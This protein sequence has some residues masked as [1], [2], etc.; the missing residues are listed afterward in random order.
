MWA[1]LESPCCMLV[2]SKKLSTEWWGPHYVGHVTRN[3]TLGGK[4]SVCVMMII[5]PFINLTLVT[6][7]KLTLI[8]H[9]RPTLI[10]LHNGDYRLLHVLRLSTLRESH[11]CYHVL[12]KPGQ[13]VGVAREK[14]KFTSLSKNRWPI[15]VFN[16][17]C[18]VLNELNNCWCNACL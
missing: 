1:F 6:R 15:I 10:G 14:K 5:I 18:P 9:L 17:A 8:Y 12:Q 7:L 2:A 16:R 13:V 4:V 3:C 11:R